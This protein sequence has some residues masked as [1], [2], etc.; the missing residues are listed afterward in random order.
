MTFIIFFVENLIHFYELGGNHRLIT[1]LP[2]M[3]MQNR[4]GI[5][6]EDG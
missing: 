6:Y 1:A 5:N 2:I 3:N 4:W